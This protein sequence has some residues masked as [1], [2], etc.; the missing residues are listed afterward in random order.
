MRE[1]QP[2]IPAAL[3]RIVSRCLKKY[4]EERY[5][6]ARILAQELRV[7]RRDTE[8][9]L[10][11]KTSL[12]Q[13][14]LDA[15]EYLQH[16]PPTRYAWFAIAAVALGLGLYFSV[17]RI[18]PGSLSFVLIVGLLLIRH[19]RNQPQRLQD[20]LVRKISKIPEVRLVRFHD[21][22]ATVVV[23]TAVAQ[24]YGRINHQLSL[25]NRKRYWGPPMTLSIQHD[26]SGDQF[27]KMLSDSGVQYVRQDDA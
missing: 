4:P 14:V 20:L 1:Q 8:A 9:G 23:D 22:H 18:G 17:S 12:R 25:F 7:L 15:W 21:R 27:R 24:L 13:R 26:V 6:N 5:P 19:V 3:Q 16:L 10:V 11:Q 2:H